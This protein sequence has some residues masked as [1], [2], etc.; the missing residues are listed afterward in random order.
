MKKINKLYIRKNRSRTHWTRY[1][2]L[3]YNPKVFV[4]SLYNKTYD[5]SSENIL[6]DVWWSSN[7]AHSEY[8]IRHILREDFTLSSFYF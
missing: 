6:L 8:L 4:Y 2:W 1:G 7:R 5:L 3:E